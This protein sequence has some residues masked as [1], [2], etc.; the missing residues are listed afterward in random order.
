MISY[1]TSPPRERK[2]RFPDEGVSG[3][4]QGSGTLPSTRNIIQNGGMMGGD[5]QEW[6]SG[7]RPMV[8]TCT[9]SVFSILQITSSPFY[10]TLTHSIS[11]TYT[12][13]GSTINITHTLLPA[14]GQ[15]S[16]VGGGGGTVVSLE[17]TVEGVGSGFYH[18]SH[19]ALPPGTTSEGTHYLCSIQP[20][21]ASC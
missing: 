4:P 7:R 11:T 15:G 17:N 14:N 13:H 6:G 21:S 3:V 16:M 10:Y 5:P 9:L 20:L 12:H 1:K 19:H 2:S 8:D 18:V